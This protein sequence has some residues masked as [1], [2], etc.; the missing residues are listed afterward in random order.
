MWNV[1][2]VSGGGA[3]RSRGIGYDVAGYISRRYSTPAPRSG[4]A[5]GASSGSRHLGPLAMVSLR[6]VIVAAICLLAG[7]CLDPR[8][9]NAHCQWTGDTST[10][11][12]DVRDPSQRAH[13]AMD[14]RVAGENAV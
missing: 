8:R 6:I 7:A 14:V 10:V 1:A 4:Q 11:A 12:L 5:P 13:L 3:S 2:G 9:L